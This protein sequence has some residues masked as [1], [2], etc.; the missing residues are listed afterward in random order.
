[1]KQMHIVIK[2]IG[3]TQHQQ[4][5]CFTIEGGT[6]S[7]VNTNNAGYISL[8]FFMNEKATQ[9]LE[10]T[11]LM[12]MLMVHLF[13]QDLNQLFVMVKNTVT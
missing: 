13:I 9:N 6:N 1:M 8:Y 3:I 4:V 11:Q 12:E 10:A 7:N 2:H 5:L